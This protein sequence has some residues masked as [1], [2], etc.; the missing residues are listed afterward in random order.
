SCQ[1]LVD[2]ENE[3]C[4]EHGTCMDE[5]GCHH[6]QPD[7]PETL[8]RRPVFVPYSQLVQELR[9][10]TVQQIFNLIEESCPDFFLEDT[11]RSL[12]CDKG[13]S[14]LAQPRHS[15][16][17]TQPIQMQE[18]VEEWEKWRGDELRSVLQKLC[19]HPSIE[20]ITCSLEQR[21]IQELSQLL[22]LLGKDKAQAVA[23]DIIQ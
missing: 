17:T 18:M 21:S 8:A 19:I 6:C 12:L 13:Y 20:Q 10:R 23:R 2:E 7:V 5:C 11:L 15:L 9:C 22:L 14:F 4:A 3:Y 1:D 16:I